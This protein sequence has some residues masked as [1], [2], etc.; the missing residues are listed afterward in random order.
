MQLV[1]RAILLVGVSA[2]PL[3]AGFHTPVV[4]GADPA[5]RVRQPRGRA[6]PENRRLRARFGR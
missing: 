1:A 2:L 3:Q 6:Q 5:R 4:D